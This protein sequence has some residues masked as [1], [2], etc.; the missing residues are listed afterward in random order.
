MRNRNTNV[1]PAFVAKIYSGIAL[2]EFVR[3]L[4]GALRL[5][6][7]HMNA[8][9]VCLVLFGRRRP[10]CMWVK[11]AYALKPDNRYALL[12]NIADTQHSLANHLLKL[13]RLLLEFKRNIGHPQETCKA[14][15]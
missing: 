5:T 9:R 8:K 12:V 1:Y 6:N 14:M 11:K 4:N 3:A 13:L 15:V 7:K 2:A 10:T